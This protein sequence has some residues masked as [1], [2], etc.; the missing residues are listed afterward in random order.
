MATETK[1]EPIVTEEKT[2][3]G[4]AL[5]TGAS[6]GIGAE[7]A[8]QLARKGYS[9]VMVARRQDLLEERAAD[10]AARY[11]IEADVL[12]ADLATPEGV[13]AV[14]K[15][16]AEGD[17]DMLVNSAGFATLGQFEELAGER[18]MEEIDVNVKALVALTHAALGPMVARGSGTVINLGSVGSFTPCPYMSTYTATKAFVLF[19]SESVHEEVRGK[20]VTV[21]C[22]CPGFVK[23]GFQE[24]AG[25]DL[26]TLR[27]PGQ[28]TPKQVVAAALKGAAA[29]RAL[30]I[31]G[32]LNGL[33]AQST[34][35]SPRFLI[36]KA[37]AGV[38]R[39]TAL[40]K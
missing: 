15:R 39:E 21:T 3:P 23:S 37:G 27:T 25:Q 20:G 22:L 14:A 28:Q 35:V 8:R 13:A 33:M 19:F 1:E 12:A 24:V 18:E 40:K 16:L 31:P 5:I 4:L 38:F 6:S 2:R 30:V 34:R 26:E 10:H 32:T 17:V 11:G 7:F 29:G 36:R 9:L